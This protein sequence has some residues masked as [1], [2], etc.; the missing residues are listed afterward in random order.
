MERSKGGKGE[1]G[2]TRRHLPAID[3][4][5]FLGL[6]SSHGIESQLVP[7]PV[8]LT[9]QSTYLCYLGRLVSLFVSLR[10]LRN[11]ICHPA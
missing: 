4:T 6:C 9:F 5:N 3:D 11:D 10:G 7:H 8:Y 1:R 2:E